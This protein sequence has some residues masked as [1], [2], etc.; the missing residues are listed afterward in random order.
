MKSSENQI[1]SE[2]KSWNHEILLIEKVIS[3]KLLIYQ[4]LLEKLQELKNIWTVIYEENIYDISW[5]RQNIWLFSYQKKW[6]MMIVYKLSETQQDNS[7]KQISAIINWKTTR[8]TKKN[9]VIYETRYSR[10]IL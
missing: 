6:K 2:H 10:K 5:I 7:K 8:M 1:L 4:L 3:E 9:Q